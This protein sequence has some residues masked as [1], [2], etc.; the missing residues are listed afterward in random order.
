MKSIKYSDD[1][2]ALRGE[3]PERVARN[4]ASITGV[5]VSLSGTGGT[6]LV[7]ATAATIYTPTT[8]SADALHG[9]MYVALAAGATAPVEGD[10]FMI[11]ASADGPA[12]QVICDHY[13]SSTRYLYLERQLQYSHTSGA[14]VVGLWATYDLDASD[15][16]VYTKGREIRVLWNPDTDD[17]AWTELYQVSGSSAAPPGFWSE[18]QA[19]YPTEYEMA[20]DRDMDTIEG[21]IRARFA[22]EFTSRG[23][24]MTRVVDSDRLTSGMILFARYVLTD[25]DDHMKAWANWLKILCDDPIWTD[26]DQ[27]GIQDDNEEQL[28]GFDPTMR[29]I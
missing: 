27:D 24:L 12:E 1:S 14:A 17:E 23:L 8:L 19:I 6:E 22:H 29:Y 16:D 11:G 10:R 25:K 7:A 18:F 15:T 4:A 21:H 13:D 26:D 28:H 5:T 20:T 9:A 3:Y 2:F